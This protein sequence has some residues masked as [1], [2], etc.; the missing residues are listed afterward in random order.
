MLRGLAARWWDDVT[1]DLETLATG[2]LMALLRW[3]TT[4]AA[5]QESGV[6]LGDQAYRGAPA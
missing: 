4:A 2:G 1:F 6:S 5:L 3:L